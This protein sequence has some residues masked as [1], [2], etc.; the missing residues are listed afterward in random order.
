MPTRL[1]LEGPDIQQLLARIRDEH[2]ASARIVS[3]DRVRG[4]GLAGLFSRQRYELTIEIDDGGGGLPDGAQAASPADSLLALADAQEQLLRTADQAPSPGPSLPAAPSLPAGPS[5]P[6]GTAPLIAPTN[7]PGPALPPGAGAGTAPPAPGSGLSFADVLASLGLA[8]PTD[9][10]A[11]PA[12]PVETPP[13]SPPEFVVTP[14]ERF[15]TVTLPAFAMPPGPAA[16]RTTPTGPNG[17]TATAPV[18]PA[19]ARPQPDPAA[20]LRTAL[21]RLGMPPQLLDQIDDI[22]A[23]LAIV[24][25]LDALGPA[26]G[27]PTGAGDVLAIVGELTAAIAVAGAVAENLQLPTTRT[28]VAAASTA[29]T[30]IHS[31]RRL[32]DPG[33]AATRVTKLR[34]GDAPLIVVVDAP[35]DGTGSAWAREVLEAMNP[36]VVWAVVDATRKAPDTRRYLSGLGHVDALAVR[37]MGVTAD[38]ATVLALDAPVALLDGDPAT[39]HTWAALLCRRIA[40]AVL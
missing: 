40:E 15:S 21:A 34:D 20:R 19:P 38:P 36:T 18:R 5:L 25:L 16:R 30:G 26:A 6:T 29:G 28:L 10:P 9:E 37:A 22:D 27:A 17:T 32:T 13:A 8:P 35:A 23:Y 12:A 31:S 33:H 3:A 39:P 11:A 1:L 24:R 2:G 7:P 14:V 4:A